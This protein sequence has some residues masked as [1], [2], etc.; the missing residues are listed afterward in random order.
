MGGIWMLFSVLVWAGS[1][2]ASDPEQCTAGATAP[3]PITGELM[4]LTDENVNICKF[5]RLHGRCF[6]LHSGLPCCSIMTSS[7]VRIGY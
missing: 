1:A 4:Y 2:V 5:I 3:K 7:D 6:S